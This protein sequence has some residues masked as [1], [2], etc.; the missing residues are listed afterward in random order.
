MKGWSWL[1][2]ET[3]LWG[4]W[5]PI[6]RSSKK[7]GDVRRTIIMNVLGNVPCEEFGESCVGYLVGTVVEHFCGKMCLCLLILHLK[8]EM[9]YVVTVFTI[10]FQDGWISCRSLPARFSF[11]SAP[12]AAMVCHFLG[13][14]LP[15]LVWLRWDKMGIFHHLPC[16]RAKPTF[17]KRPW[18]G[19]RT[20]AQSVTSPPLPLLSW[21]DTKWICIRL[22]CLGER[23]GQ[24]HIRSLWKAK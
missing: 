17:A 11:S 1:K 16:G 22:G 23:L 9:T 18:R 12:L 5:C 19:Q 2:P 8:M 21:T 4:Y 24:W 3:N 6:G 14:Q 7:I 15:A 13:S 10:I 20:Q